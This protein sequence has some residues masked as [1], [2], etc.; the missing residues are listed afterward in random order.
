M[1]GV[2][3]LHPLGG[4][5][6]HHL[7]V[8]YPAGSLR[9]H[10][11]H[12]DTG[13]LRNDDPPRR[14]LHRHF[15]HIPLSPDTRYRSFASIP[16]LTVHILFLSLR[17]PMSGGKQPCEPCHKHCTGDDDCEVRFDFT[18]GCADEEKKWKRHEH[19]SNHRHRIGSGR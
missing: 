2:R 1:Y 6:S 15:I 9:S 4:C 10:N 17:Y 19:K 13:V 8:V 11:L 18:D 14:V 3:R 7:R 16:G 5:I 12:N